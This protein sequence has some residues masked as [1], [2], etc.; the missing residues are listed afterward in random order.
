VS[1]SLNGNENH[2]IGDLFVVVYYAM[3]SVE[4]RPSGAY[5]SVQRVERE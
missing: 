2:F 4:H 1:K 3:C 5:L